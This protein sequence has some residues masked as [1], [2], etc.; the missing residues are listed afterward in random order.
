MV[1]F[2]KRQ[3]QSDYLDR[4]VNI[5]TKEKIDTVDEFHNTLKYLTNE[6]NEPIKTERKIKVR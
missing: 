2:R 3:S 4:K 1:F 5:F 6:D